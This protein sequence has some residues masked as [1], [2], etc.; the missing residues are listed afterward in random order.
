[1]QNESLIQL[2][3]QGDPGAINSLLS[4]YQ[5]SL[6]RFA[7]KHCATPEDA[8]DAVQETLWVIFRKIK[9]LRAGMAFVSWMFQIVRNH[10]Y[11]LL[12]KTYRSRET[13]ELASR[14][15]LDRS[16]NAEEALGEI[17]QKDLS[18]AI[19]QLPAAQREVLILRD[20]QGMSAPEV[21]S[22]LG[23]KIETVKSRLHYARNALRQILG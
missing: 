13:V 9:T 20:L 19:R 21:A 6:S 2:A 7:R 3:I 5:P 10:C 22:F 4:R 23:V 1:M 17:H 15:L 18:K 11:A 12:R 14:D 8:E 16:R